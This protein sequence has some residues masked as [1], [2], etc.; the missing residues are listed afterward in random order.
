M[1]NNQYL[2]SSFLKF[3]ILERPKLHWA[4][5]PIPELSRWAALHIS[6]LDEW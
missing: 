1:S 2:F 5:I 4:N 3:Q 6:I